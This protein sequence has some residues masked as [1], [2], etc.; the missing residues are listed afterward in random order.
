MSVRIVAN[1]QLYTFILSVED[2]VYA[3][4]R[5]AFDAII[6]ATRFSPPNTGA[7]LMSKPSNRWIQ[8]EY[9]FSLDLPEGWS[10]VLAPARSRPSSPT[11][12]RTASGPT[13]SSCWRM[14]IETSILATSPKN[15]P[16]GSARRIALAKSCPAR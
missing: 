13:I 14:P 15:S 2:S 3:K 4:A 9:K 8:R 5:P 10:P 11:A 16:I 7:D 12:R 6:V 1:R